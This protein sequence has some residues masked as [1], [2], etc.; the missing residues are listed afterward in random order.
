MIFRDD[1]RHPPP[2]D[3]RR[4]QRVARPTRVFVPKVLPDDDPAVR[5]ARNKRLAAL[6]ESWSA[7]DDV[8]EPYPETL[9]Q[10]DLGRGG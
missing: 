10:L 6:I 8:E 1:P 9:E 5:V 2:R 3:P 4:R 7:D